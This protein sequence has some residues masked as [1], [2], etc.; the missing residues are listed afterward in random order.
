ML[1]RAYLKLISFWCEKVYKFRMNFLV[2]K[3]ELRS[4]LVFWFFLIVLIGFEIYSFI[5]DS[6]YKWDGLFL[7]GLLIFV[8]KFKNKLFL[9]PLHLFLFGIFLVVHNLGV[10]GFYFNHY[11]GIEFDT[12]VHFYFG[13]VSTLILWNMYGHLVQKKDIWIKYAALLTIGLGLS[14]F[15]ELLEYAG[16]VLFGEGWGFLLAGTGDMEMWDVQ[17]D[18]RNNLFGGLVVL[19][20]YWIRSKF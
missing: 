13:L 7:I 19:G 3:K 20:Y 2:M 12:Y 11:L 4:N 5:I 8:Y 9:K 17:T 18:M 10:F 1:E 15:H 16:G 6:S 14:A